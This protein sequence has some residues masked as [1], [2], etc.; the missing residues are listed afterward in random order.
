MGTKQIRISERLY[1]RIKDEKRT[2]ETMG[3]ALERM[4]GGYDLLD[5][6]A[7]AEGSETLDVERIE[8]G[9][10]EASERNAAEA[11]EDL[12]VE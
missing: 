5:F 3:E 9:M 10:L 8:T 11:R 2:D 7:D 4:V 6:A 12:G 1:A